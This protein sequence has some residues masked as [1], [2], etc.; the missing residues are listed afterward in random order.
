V[1]RT[2]AERRVV[3]VDLSYGSCRIKIGSLDGEDFVVSPE[4]TDA[5]RLAAEAGLPLPRVYEDARAAY[6]NRQQ[7]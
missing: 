5:A 6:E 1:G 2:V 3:E 7:V 4:Y